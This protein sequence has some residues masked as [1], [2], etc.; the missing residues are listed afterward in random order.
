[1]RRPIRPEELT[2]VAQQLDKDGHKE[3]AALIRE[4]AGPDGWKRLRAS[5][6]SDIAETSSNLPLTMDESLKFKL[7]AEALRMNVSLSAVVAEGYQA[8]LHGEW[9]PPRVQRSSPAGYVKSV[10]N[11][12]LDNGLRERVRHLLPSLTESAGYRVTESSIAVSWMLEEFG[13]ERSGQ[14]AQSSE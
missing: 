4:V 1:M 8:V 2:A 13:L 9:M 5:Y 14:S 10:L 7:R 6:L 3:S 12:R 11:V